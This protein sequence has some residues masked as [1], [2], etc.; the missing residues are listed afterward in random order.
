MYCQ[1][2]IVLLNLMSC[3]GRGGVGEVC[4][5]CQLCIVLLNLM[6]CK[7]RGVGWGRC[8][9]SIVYCTFKPYVL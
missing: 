5:G 1:L 6:S 2:C 3:K 9:L 7:G 4:K 8:V